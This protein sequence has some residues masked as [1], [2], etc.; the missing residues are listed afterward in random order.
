MKTKLI[1][2]ANPVALAKAVTCPTV[3]KKPTSTDSKITTGFFG[4]LL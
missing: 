2:T 3:E 4:L 1:T